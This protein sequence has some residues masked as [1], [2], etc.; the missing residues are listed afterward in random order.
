MNLL[1][2][3]E[4]SGYPTEYLVARIRGRRVYLVKD[5]DDILSSPVPLETILPTYYRE[6]VTEY[7]QEGV[8]KRVLK[9]F[10]WVY[11]QMNRKLRSIFHPFFTYSEI[12]TMVL[13]LRFETGKETKT[14][15]EDILS[16]S[17][18]SKEV[19][20]VLKTRADLPFL[21]EEFERKF[22]SSWD[23]PRGLK[24]IFS[25]DGLKGIEEG[26]SSGFIEQIINSKLHPVLKNFFIFLIDIKNIMTLYKHMRWAVKTDPLLI[27][28]GSISESTLMNTVHSGEI[29]RVIRLVYQLT[30][31]TVPETG[32]SEIENTLFTGLTKYLRVKAIGSTDIGL[33]LDYLWK[34]YIEA[35]NFSIL[36]YSR[37]IERKSLR[38]EL[39]T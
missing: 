24:E 28:G 7:A 16:F 14:D 34:I 3:P 15:I 11:F 26:L 5:W 12:K 25:E 18:L 17:L 37:D 21:L 30:G 33:I 31:T 32:A 35:Q 6:F 27:Q 9:E 38:K 36:L 23:K 20:E 10:R 1:Q 4:G 8:W 22:L 13:C 2:S 19:K 29:S 39:V